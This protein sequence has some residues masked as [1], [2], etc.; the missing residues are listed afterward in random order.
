MTSIGALLLRSS[1]FPWLK[2]L[3]TG[4]VPVQSSRPGGLVKVLPINSHGALVA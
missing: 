1:R 2:R 3:A 4:G